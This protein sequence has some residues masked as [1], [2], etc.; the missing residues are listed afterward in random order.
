MREGITNLQHDENTQLLTNGNDP[1]YGGVTSS[2]PPVEASQPEAD[3]LKE[4]NKSNMTHVISMAIG[5]LLV[6]MD[7]T[8]VV[9]SY[10]SIGSELNQLQNTSWIATAYMLTQTCFQP[11]SGK[12]SDIFGRKTCLLTC[13]TIFAL[14]C[15]LCGLS[16]SMTQLIAARA[17]A[18]IGGGGMASLVT[19]IMSDVV[20]L[21]SRG[22]WQGV[23]NVIYTTGSAI[24]APLGGFLADSIGWRWAFLLQVPLCVVA[25]SSVLLTLNL[26]AAQASSLSANIKRIDFGG[27]ISLI[28]AVFFLLFGMDRGGNI[29]W[30]DRFTVGSLIAFAI[31]VA[32]F[33][34]IEISVATEP[35]A[36]K[37]IITNRSLMACYLVNFCG[38][39]ASLA[40]IFNIS[41]FY[42]AVQ[43]KTASEASFWLV[44][45]I[46]GALIGS[47]SGGLTIQHTGKYYAITVMSYFLLAIGTSTVFLSS[48]VVSISTVALAI[49]LSVTNAGNASGVT[50]TL[51]ALIAN[52][53]QADQAIATAVSYLFR[54][55][56]CI[57]GLSIGSTLVQ[58]TLRYLLHQRLSGANVEEIIRH[59]Q[60]SLD[61]L[62]QLDPLTKA[63][64]VRSYEEA[65]Q[66]TF[67]FT[68]VMAMVS[69]LFSL[70][71]R[72]RELSH[73]ES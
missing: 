39:A 51:I 70:L 16:M 60:E 29:S 40:Q 25:F 26:P 19:I 41:L 68:V 11:L 36:P 20:P 54:S 73:R 4:E 8:I 49:G 24:G 2:G 53:G 18:G 9:S 10:A 42:Q 69:A 32:L 23:L 58:N 65:I 66:V 46:V 62:N 14:G 72:E 12:L 1:S 50:T 48:G 45:C 64:V 33:I 61:Y 28:L 59:I 6:A 13:Y 44:I 31:L 43:G 67:L 34:F 37:R 22:T 21:R 55:L 57:V 27:A 5:I 38:A 47:L 30:N 3:I 7:G 35:F 71:I 15:L 17:I 63:T 56:G 52:A